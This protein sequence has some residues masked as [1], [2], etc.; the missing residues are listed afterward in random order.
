MKKKLLTALITLLIYNAN[1]QSYIGL[2]TDNYKGVHGV[3]NNP[4]SIANSPYKVDI[5]LVGASTLVSNDFYGFQFFDLFDEDFEFENDA[6]KFPETNNSLI[7]NIDVLG[8]SFMF[9]LNEKS[10]IAVFTR[11]RIFANANNIDGEQAE[12]LQDGFDEDLPFTFIEDS[13]YGAINTWTEI[14]ITYAREIFNKEKHYLKGG[15]TL[16]YLSGFANAY[17]TI[18]NLEL[19]YNGSDTITAN[20]SFNYGFSEVLENDFDNL[21]DLDFEMEASGFGGDIGFEYEWRPKYKDYASTDSNIYKIKAGISVTDIGFLNYDGQEDNFVFDNIDINSDDFEDVE[22]IEDFRN[23]F[24]LDNVLTRASGENAILPTALHLNADWNINQKFYLN[25]NTDLALVGKEKINANSIANMTSLTP[26][27]E[28]KWITFQM[29]FSLQQYS[30][31]LWGAGLRAG[32]LYVGSGSI[33]SSF[34]NDELKAADIYAGLKIP[35]Y[36]SKPKDKDGD[37][38]INKEDNC[39]NEP[40]SADNNGCPWGDADG[41]GIKD[42]KDNC[43]NEPGP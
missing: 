43:P 29:P 32:P 22:D 36:K 35:I 2:L 19:D 25:L 5:N 15:I 23:L 10:S 6:V 7:S 26:R 4:A 13:S 20:G 9:N 16:K 34:I 41:D 33:V 40:G 42:N 30:G 3:I 28:C 1:A 14:G 18:N 17:Y 12:G 31:F 27:F 38:I 39:P 8:P 21:E 37:G 11:A 24:D